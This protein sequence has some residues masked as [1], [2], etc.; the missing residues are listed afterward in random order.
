[1]GMKIAKENLNRED[2]VKA[3]ELLEKWTH[4]FSTDRTHLGKSNL[5]Q[6]EINLA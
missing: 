6:H 4:V 2:I 1:M 5:V 3:E